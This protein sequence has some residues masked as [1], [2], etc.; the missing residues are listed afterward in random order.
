MLKNYQRT[1]SDYLRSG[2]E[3]SV[4]KFIQPEYIGRMQIYKN[5]FF[6]ACLAAL[7]KLYAKTI[8]IIGEECFNYYARLF[9]EA[10]PPCESSLMF[11]SYD[12][13]SYLCSQK[14]ME[15]LEYLSD[16]MLL[17]YSIN[18]VYNAAK[19]TELTSEEA[20]NLSTKDVLQLNMD[21]KVLQCEYN[22][23]DI[24]DYCI[25]CLDN[26]MNSRDNLVVNKGA[27]YVVMYRNGFSVVH[28]PI[29]EAEYI[30]FQAFENNGLTVERVFENI[31]MDVDRIS[32]AFAKAIKLQL[33][34]Y[35]GA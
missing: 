29:K 6:I 21:V 16:M 25:N 26:P 35:K 34:I 13:I 32:M 8:L 27:Y 7:K 10:N 22:V 11:Y 5:N 2:D 20:V 30:V 33:L 9:I 14:V 28:H 31:K 24:Y 23:L 17:E 15:S 18:E 12:F 1:F 3:S 4:T 19:M